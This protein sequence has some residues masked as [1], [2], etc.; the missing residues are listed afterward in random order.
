[1]DPVC[2]FV[3]VMAVLVVPVWLMERPTARA[4]DA[5]PLVILAVVVM[6]GV[7]ALVGSSKKVVEDPSLP[8]V[9]SFRS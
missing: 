9:I 3:L 4:G 7:L 5:I 1:M 6:L 2:A 8:P